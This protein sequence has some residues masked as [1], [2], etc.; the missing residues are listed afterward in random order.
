MK[1]LAFN[2]S[3]RKIGNSMKLLTEAVRGATDAGAEVSIVQ[4]YEMNFKGCRSCFGCK[5]LSPL[6]GKGCIQK[7]DF[8]PVMQEMLNVDAWI[9]AS[10]IYMGHTSSSLSALL[11]RFHFSHLNYDSHEKMVSRDYPS[12]FLYSMNGNSDFMHKNG[13][14]HACQ[15]DAFL[16]EEAFGSCEWMIANSTLQFEDYSKYHTAAVPVE[17]KTQFSSIQFPKDLQRAYDLG[18]NLVS[19][20]SYEQ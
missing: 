12:I 11:E 3:A 20:I 16:M 7:D 13:I 18:K 14:E 8:T 15:Y 1:I 10:P 6:Y 19:K 17:K 5:R 4:L 2:G 9:F